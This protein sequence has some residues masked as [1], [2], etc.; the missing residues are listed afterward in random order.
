MWKHDRDDLPVTPSRFMDEFMRLKRGSVNRRHFLGVTGLGLAAAVMGAGGRP[1]W[2]EAKAQELGDHV[3]LNSWPN[4]HDP[5]TF[6]AFTA[7]TGITVHLTVSNSNEEMLKKLRT[8][9]AH[10]DLFVPT[11]YAISTYVELGLIDELALER[12]THYSAASQNLLF[13][14]A[15]QV[16]GRTYAVPKNWGTTGMATNTDQIS[17]PIASWKDFFAVAMAE[18][19]GRTVVHDYQ[20]TTIGSALVSLGHSF[21]SV[22]PTELAAAE[23]LLLAVKPHLL[24]V[25]SDYQPAMRAGDA[26]LAMCWASDGQQLHRDLP[27]IEFRLGKD[28]GEIWTDYF[29]IPSAAR[30]KA[31]AYALV[32]FMMDPQIAVK[33][34][35]VNGA[36]TTDSRVL[37]LL[38]RE[39]RTNKIIYPD[40]AALTEL[41]FGA[42]VT[43]T[44]PGRAELMARFKAA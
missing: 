36:A 38:P 19:S 25:D 20:L 41:E 34:H 2:R 32:D 44:D 8:G 21:N 15:G 22:D 40:K 24:A 28:G 33:E 37:E 14:W 39:I 7:A 43:L 26:W 35:I 10:W 13:T 16:S 4:Y 9:V 30:N 12:F 17:A 1:S 29:A 18:A 27:E 42:A 23:K 31:A 11:N 6:E 5:A 3:R